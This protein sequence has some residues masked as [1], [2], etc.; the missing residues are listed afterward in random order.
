[1]AKVVSLL[2]SP[3]IPIVDLLGASREAADPLTPPSSGGAKSYVC[4]MNLVRVT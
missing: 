3:S 1:M 4:V 2:H